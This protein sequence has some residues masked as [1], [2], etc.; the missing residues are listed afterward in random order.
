MDLRSSPVLTAIV[1][2]VVAVACGGGQ[3]GTVSPERSKAEKAARKAV[4]EERSLEGKK[5]EPRSVGILPFEVNP[6]DTALVALGYGLADLLTTDLARS[7]RLQ[8]VDRVQLNAILREI[9]LVESGKI[10]TSSAPRV[11]KLIQARR[12]VLGYLGWTPK[13][14]LGLNANIADIQSG[15][16][17]VAIAARTNIN[18]ILRAE[19][20]LAFDLFDK[21][22]VRLTPKERAAVEQMPTRNVDAF[23]AYSRGVRFEAEGRYNAAAQE[24][25]QA[26]G[27]DPGFKA[28]EAHLGAVQSAALGPAP[29]QQASAGA[30]P[31]TRAADVVTD[32]I[33]GGFL[34]PLGSQLIATP[35]ES[36]T[37]DLPT[38]TTIIITVTVPP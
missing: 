20:Q 18:D 33:S 8:V 26:S 3:P 38:P 9:G 1:T 2:L 31:A 30:A 4:A 37:G 21:L 12:L 22:G 6:P 36:G 19:K 7:K 27:L 23:L 35:P 14:E 16:V 15:D 28:A 25:R 29:T 17:Q 5:L 10:D 32:R 24:Y 11:G 34:S 13:G